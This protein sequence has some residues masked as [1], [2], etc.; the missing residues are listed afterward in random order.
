MARSKGEG[1]I[2]RLEDKPKAKC[3]LWRLKA[4]DWS[5]KTRYRRFRGTYSQAEAAM[6]AFKAEISAPVSDETFGS[7]SEKWL[8]R[9]RRGGEIASQTL[10]ENEVELKRL[11][12]EFGELPL[13]AIDRS[14]VVDGLASIK[15][16]NTPSGRRLSGT[17]M[18][19][20][21]TTMRMVMREAQMDGIIDANPLDLVKPPKRDT[22]EKRALPFDQVRRAVALLDSL[23]LDAHTVAV[24]LML[25]GGLRRSEAVGLEWRDVR[26]GMLFVSRSVAE[27]T[28]EVKEPKTAAGM[29]AVPMLPQLESSL[30]EWREAQA[31]ILRYLG[32]EQTGATPIVTSA[33]GTRMRAQNLE[34]WWRRH[35]SEVG[36]DC[37]PHELRHTFLTML[38]NSGANAATLTSIAGWSSIEMASVYV[39]DDIEANEAAVGMLERRFE[40]GTFAG[41]PFGTFADVRNVPQRTVRYL[42]NPGQPQENVRN[43][44]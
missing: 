38:A 26:N 24:R 17:T 25:L 8:E 2:T 10:M 13:Q 42:E 15:G 39:H 34:R 7:Y 28:G 35:M 31:G 9:R 20:T 1:G 6:R 30:E 23:P 11:R 33:T 29:R 41:T 32:I 43:V 36:V 44:P 3:R 14:R 21:Y 37:R 18:A 4:V 40:G 19:K 5:G 12:M 16:G 27:R 22:P